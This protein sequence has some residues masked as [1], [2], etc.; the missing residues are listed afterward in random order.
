MR[1][2]IVCGQFANHG[3]WFRFF[4]ETRRDATP[5]VMVGGCIGVRFVRGGVAEGRHQLRIFGL[6]VPARA[7]FAMPAASRCWCVLAGLP[8]VVMAAFLGARGLGGR[9]VVGQ[10]CALGRGAI[11]RTRGGY[12]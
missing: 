1:V 3:R 5:S 12:R 6:A 4:G 10:C 9:T 11:Q 2:T 7:V 8:G